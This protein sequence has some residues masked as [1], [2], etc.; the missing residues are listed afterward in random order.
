MREHILKLKLELQNAV[1]GAVMLENCYPQV[2][3]VL[4][5]INFSNTEIFNYQELWAVIIEMYNENTPIDICTV[6]NA[7]FKKHHRNEAWYITQMTNRIASAANI[8]YHAFIILQYDLQVKY[9]HLLHEVIL[10]CKEN[11]PTIKSAL[12]EVS[13]TIFLPEA[14]I[15]EIIRGSIDWFR[16]LHI[17]ED[18]L[19]PITEFKKS[20]DARCDEIKKLPQAAYLFRQFRA[21]AESAKNYEQS[22]AY[23]EIEK[24]MRKLYFTPDISPQ[25]LTKLIEINHEL[26]TAQ[27]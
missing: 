26:E 24:I 27:A 11:E 2:A 15:I 22:S 6:T 17:R 12:F 1:A 21:I 14:D 8:Q 7:F 4:K 3:H 16:T 23:G 18:L 10:Q 9:E 19:E 13:E 20:F 5:P 25:L